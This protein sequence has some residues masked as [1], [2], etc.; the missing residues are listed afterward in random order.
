MK[1]SVRLM[2]V[3]AL[4]C[5]GCPAWATSVTLT[6]S[7]SGDLTI[8]QALADA[9]ATVADLTGNMYDDI[10]VAGNGN[11]LFDTDI[12][13]YTGTIH[14]SSG[15]TVK[16]TA[17][18]GCGATSGK[19]YVA[20]GGALIPDAT[21]FA[22]NAFTMPKDE[23]HLA[24]AGPDG[25]GALVAVADANQRLGIWGNSLTRSSP[26]AWRGAMSWISPSNLHRQASSI[27]T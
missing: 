4:V 27:W 3:A 10:V 15:A 2:L 12:S 8:S 11:I 23:I 18:G 13:A 7:S 9:G 14:I 24:G 21:G 5:G 26:T 22:A 20:D 17:L 19:V 1:K 25:K 6:S 16:V